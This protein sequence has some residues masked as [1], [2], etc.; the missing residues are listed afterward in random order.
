MAMVLLT[1]VPSAPKTSI[2]NKIRSVVGC[3]N[4]REIATPARI[5]RT[6][7]KARNR[8]DG[9]TGQVFFRSQIVS[10]KN[11]LAARGCAELY[12]SGVS[13]YGLNFDRVH[14]FKF[15]RP[16]ML[17]FPPTPATPPGRSSQTSSARETNDPQFQ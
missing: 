5:D 11:A 9:S 1:V 17:S 3:A 4:P 7:R 8:R 13:S 12:F 2:G 15:A 10:M 14:F 6:A 16:K